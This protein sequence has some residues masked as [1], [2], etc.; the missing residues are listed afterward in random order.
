MVVTKPI[1]NHS[2]PGQILGVVAITVGLTVGAFGA[3]AAVSI[4]TSF[5]SRATAGPPS[6]GPEGSLPITAAAPSATIDPTP[7]ASPTPD[8]TPVPTQTPVA[9]PTPAPPTTP[10]A[11]PAANGKL[12]VV[13]LSAQ[14]LT[15]YE[16]GAPY[17]TT[18]VATGRP[19]LATPAGTFH[20][21]AKYTPYKFVSPWPKGD[22]YWYPSEWVSYAMLFADDGF[23]LHD[24]PWRTVYGPG[25]NL[26]QGTHGCVN[27]PLSVMARL[28]IWAGVGTTVVIQ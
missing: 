4:G 21:K 26:T 22:P 12:I 2:L 13:S 9:T 14:R 20:I 27:V 23:F 19:A 3:Y 25:A 10:L 8:P 18:V 16:N 7:A 1:R 17:L 15:A 24:A 28:Y 6:G 5:A 11:T